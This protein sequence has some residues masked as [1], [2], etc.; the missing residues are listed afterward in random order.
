VK[1]LVALAALAV[2]L[3][4]LMISGAPAAE[5]PAVPEVVARVGGQPV[6]RAALYEEAAA[7]LEQVATQRLS[8]ER[9]A[10]RG[11]HTALE[12]AV[13][14]LV[15]KR[16]FTLEA[17]RRGVTEDALRAEV[18]GSV[19]EVTAADIDEFYLQNQSRINQPKDKV[20]EQIKAYLLQQRQQ[21]IEEE[22]FTTAQNA[23]EV[24]VLLEPLRVTVAEGG[25]P[26]KGPEAAPITIVEF[27]DFECPYCKRVLPTLTQLHEKFPDQVRVVYRHFPLSS[28]PNAQKSAEASLCASDQGKFWE[29]HD[30]MF[31][32]Q[33]KLT[34]AD[35][36][37]KA[38]RLELDAAKF[39]EC[40]DSGRHAEAVKTDARE[41]SA[42][43][44][45]GTPAFFINGRFLSGAVPF[46]SF[47]E[48]IEDELRRKQRG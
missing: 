37:D 34:V 9:E 7:D 40:L 28:H 36:K 2:A 15:R 33:Q 26:G 32:E 18:K 13:E 46:E 23:F 35:L 10:E 20:A 19:K 31:E 24:D 29:M 11:E 17:G 14:R 4:P 21:Q 48:V 43:G 30:L 6:E 1:P 3:V 45:N 41:G 38:A 8:C 47:T 12:G 5:N 44:V 42:A 16:L 22:F 25:S 39:A 27:S